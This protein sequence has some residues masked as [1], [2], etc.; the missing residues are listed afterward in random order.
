MDSPVKEGW[1][2]FTS[3]ASSARSNAG[4][5]AVEPF[6][7]LGLVRRGSTPLQSINEIPS[8][9]APARSAEVSITE[10]TVSSVACSTGWTLAAQGAFDLALGVASGELVAL[11]VFSPSAADANFEFGESSLEVEVERDQGEAALG[12]GF[13]ELFDF[14]P[15]EQQSAITGGVVIGLARRFIARDVRT[16]QMEFTVAR[17]AIGFLNR[18][19][20]GAYALD[21]GAGQA[22]AGFIGA[23]N[24]VLVP[25]AAVASDDAI[26]GGSAVTGSSLL[27]ARP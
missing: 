27:A 11:F 21:F 7:P 14:A 20:T 26:I 10:A 23:Q 8:W 17:S 1:R 25:G 12:E 6:R 22:E 5:T 24:F 19:S 9:S 15:M 13:F 2:G 3:G 16:E 18:D 4:S